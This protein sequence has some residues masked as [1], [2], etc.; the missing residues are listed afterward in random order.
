M[1]VASCATDIGAGRYILRCSQR[2][3]FGTCELSAG[4]E[5]GW[6]VVNYVVR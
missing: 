3:K 5:G 1:D 6:L 4:K 2:A